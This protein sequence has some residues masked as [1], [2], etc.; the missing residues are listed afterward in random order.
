MASHLLYCYKIHFTCVI[1]AAY[2]VATTS[3]TLYN[4]NT[5]KGNNSNSSNSSNTT[6][7]ELLSSS[8]QE[9]DSVLL[10]SMYTLSFVVSVGLTV[11]CLS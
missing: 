11:F 5:S 3:S 2:V 9:I 4:T 6:I 8:I 10:S 7:A 1:I